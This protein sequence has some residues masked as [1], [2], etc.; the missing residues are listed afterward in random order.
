MGKAGSMVLWSFVCLVAA[1][2]VQTALQ[3]NARTVFAFARDGALP[4]RGFFGRIAKRTQ[5]PV[6]AVWFVVVISVL[7]G[8]LSFASLTAVQAVFSMVCALKPQ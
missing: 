2:T 5:T 6:N 4:D 3:A 8:V 7:M 1:F